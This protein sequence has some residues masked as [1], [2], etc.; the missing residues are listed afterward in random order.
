MVSH[1]DRAKS[2]FSVER[3]FQWIPSP[4]VTY[5]FD[6]GRMKNSVH[7]KAVNRWVPWKMHKYT[8]T[9][10]HIIYIK[11]IQKLNVYHPTNTWLPY[12]TRKKQLYL[13]FNHKY[14]K[15]N[16]CH[17]LIHH[18]KNNKKIEYTYELYMYKIIKRIFTS[19]SY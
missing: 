2:D 1:T 6:V 14:T 10:I 7:N 15:F 5:E 17:Y 4:G 11:C 13:H 8:H 16:I 9:H 19:I 12:S 18:K 3:I